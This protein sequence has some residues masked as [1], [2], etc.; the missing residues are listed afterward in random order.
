[1]PHYLFRCLNGLPGIAS[2]AGRQPDETQASSESF[3]PPPSP[4]FPLS[5]IQGPN[6]VLFMGFSQHDQTTKSEK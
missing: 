6:Y 4:P 5:L 3:N 2:G 1:V